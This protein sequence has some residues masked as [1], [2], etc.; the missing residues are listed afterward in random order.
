MIGW[1]DFNRPRWQNFFLQRMGTDG[2]GSAYP[3]LE[4]VSDFGVWCKEIPFKL[5]EGV[6]E[7]AKRT[8]NDE[9]GDDEYIPSTGLWLSA[10]EMEVEFGC[11]HVCNPFCIGR[12]D[13]I[14][15]VREAVGDF[16]EYLRGAGMMR[17]YS[18]WTRIGRQDVRFVS[19][20]DDAHW[21]PYQFS[22]MRGG[23]VV[24]R[25]EEFAVFK[26]RF[27]VNDPVT[28]VTLQ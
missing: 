20:S 18:S 2:G 8:W 7:P 21:E 16:I 15:D 28:D 26:V 6:K 19:V 3:V 9:H 22:V 12:T 4:S 14:D 5:V 10:Y 17:L 25:K 11:K 1:Q 13:N 24:P 27:K 23:R